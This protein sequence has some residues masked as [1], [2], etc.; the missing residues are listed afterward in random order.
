MSDVNE[1]GLNWDEPVDRRTLLGKAAV[2][3]GVIAAGGLLTAGRA[4]AVRPRPPET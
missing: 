2:A 3:G 1:P 4:S